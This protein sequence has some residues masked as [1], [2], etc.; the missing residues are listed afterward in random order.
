MSLPI[1][2]TKYKYTGRFEYINNIDSTL[3]CYRTS[4]QALLQNKYMP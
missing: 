3:Y 1:E 4:D 2:E